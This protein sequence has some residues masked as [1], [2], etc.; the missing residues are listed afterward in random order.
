[1]LLV[2]FYQ[3]ENIKS[4]TLFNSIKNALSSMDIS[5]TE[6]NVQCYDEASKMVVAKTRVATRINETESAPL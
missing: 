1:M 6:C 2:E 3:V 5:V 4:E